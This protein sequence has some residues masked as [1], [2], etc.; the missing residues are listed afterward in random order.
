MIAANCGLAIVP[1]WG[2]ALVV[3]CAMLACGILWREWRRE[4]PMRRLVVASALAMLLAGVPLSADVVFPRNCTEDYWRPI[5]G[6]GWCICAWWAF[7]CDCDN[8]NLPG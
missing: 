4:V 5:C 1:W 3:G 6:E 7:G 2:W 8:P